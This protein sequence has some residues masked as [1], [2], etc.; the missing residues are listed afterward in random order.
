[1]HPVPSE[2]GSSLG[3]PERRA[4]RGL[5][6]PRAWVTAGAEEAPGPAPRPPRPETGSTPP[7]PAPPARPPP[8]WAQTA[9]ARSHSPPGREPR[10]PPPPSGPPRGRRSSAAPPPPPPP[11]S[12]P[13]ARQRPP[14]ASTCRPS[15]HGRGR[16]GAGAARPL[17]PSAGAG[18]QRAR[19][20]AVGCRGQDLSAADS[21]GRAREAGRRFPPCSAPSAGSDRTGRSELQ[22]APKRQLCGSDSPCAAARRPEVVKRKRERRLEGSRKN[23]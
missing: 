17:P 8:P 6:W 11:P 10:R 2:A 22:S 4:R 23:R 1:M 20:V 12:A 19:R 9:P 21:P 18:E 16:G 15:R 14:P 5:G 7:A 3:L 13:H